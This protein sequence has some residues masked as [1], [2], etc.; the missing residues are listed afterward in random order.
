MPKT[1]ESSLFDKPLSRGGSLEPPRHSSLVNAQNLTQRK[2]TFIRDP[3][4]SHQS[5]A[6]SVVSMV[7][8]EIVE[9]HDSQGVFYEKPLFL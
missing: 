7:H 5:R 9:I 3:L 2:P 8:S 4:P 6:S 1:I